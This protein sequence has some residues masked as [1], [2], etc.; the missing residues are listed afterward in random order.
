MNSKKR[1]ER[2]S[3][4]HTL[5]LS[6]IFC[7]TL[8]VLYFSLPQERRFRYEFHKGRPWMH[9][10]L[11]APYTFAILK[12]EKAISMERDSVLNNLVPYLDLEDSIGK[13]QL[14]AVSSKIDEIFRKAKTEIF[15]PRVIKPKVLEI[16]EKI[17]NKGILEQTASNYPFLNNKRKEVYVI[18][19][20]V[21]QKAPVEQLYSLKNAYTE[22]VAELNDLKER[23]IQFQDRIADLKNNVISLNSELSQFHNKLEELKLNSE[24][25]MNSI[26]INSTTKVMLEDNIIKSKHSSLNKMV[27]PNVPKAV[28]GVVNTAVLIPSFSHSIPVE[29]IST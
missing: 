16:F 12:S 4:W 2:S 7:L 14:L 3:S 6:L 5:Y 13:K 26:K 28:R 17:Y 29:E 23:N 18:R 1:K 25:Y 9:E 10:T 8:V 11:I 27:S 21:A 20:N 22:A 24:N 15:Y 19:N